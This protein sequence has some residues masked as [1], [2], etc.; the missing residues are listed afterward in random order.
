MNSWPSWTTLLAKICVKYCGMVSDKNLLSCNP[1]NWIFFLSSCGHIQYITSLNDYNNQPTKI[2]QEC[3]IYIS[4]L[5]HCPSVITCFVS[6]SSFISLVWH[7][8]VLSSHGNKKKHSQ[9][10]IC[11]STNL[12]EWQNISVEVLFPLFFFY[13]ADSLLRL[14]V[15]FFTW[16][17]FC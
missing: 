15:F 3:D 7:C 11:P 4:C 2:W 6:E 9:R 14:V 13:T 5:S 16:P 10:L 1:G 12:L 17:R 8:S